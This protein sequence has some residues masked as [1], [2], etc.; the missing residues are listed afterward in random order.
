[1]GKLEAGIRAG[2][3]TGVPRRA[4]FCVIST[5]LS[6]DPPWKAGR[7]PTP[8]LDSPTHQPPSSAGCCAVIRKHNAA[9]KKGSGASLE[10]CKFGVCSNLSDFSKTLGGISLCFGGGV[11]FFYQ[12]VKCT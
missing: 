2:E 1:M 6:Q 8:T 12:E 3:E 4:A 10:Y 7:A 5:Q 11:F 9:G